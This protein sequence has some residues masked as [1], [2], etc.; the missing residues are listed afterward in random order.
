MEAPDAITD[1]RNLK[2][3]VDAG[4]THL[5]SQLFFDNDAFYRFYEKTRIAGIDVPV[6][7]GLFMV[8]NTPLTCIPLGASSFANARVKLFTPPLDAL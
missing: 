4:V 5:V 1:I 6:E 7:A 8:K 2:K 3:K